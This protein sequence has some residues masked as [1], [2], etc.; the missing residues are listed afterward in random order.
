MKDGISIVVPAYN[1]EEGICDFLSALVPVLKNLGRE[2]EVLII[3][4]GSTDRTVERVEEWREG[5]ERIKVFS[6]GENRG[7][8]FALSVGFSMASL[9]LIGY[10]DADIPFYMGLWGPAIWFLEESGADMLCGRR[11][12]RH[13]EGARRYIYT[14]GFN[15]LVSRALKIKVHDINSPFK[16]IRKEI[17]ERVQLVSEK[18]L[19]DAE[20]IDKVQ[21]AGGRIVE[22]PYDYRIRSK[23]GTKLGNVKNAV[24]TFADLVKYLRMRE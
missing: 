9:P 2:F 22:F 24:N 21:R 11:T 19:I 17:L 3:D 1:E 6:L 20:L 10:C 14:V 13:I 16:I 7:I 18:S 23:G 4:D 5:G 15:V 12:N 8:G